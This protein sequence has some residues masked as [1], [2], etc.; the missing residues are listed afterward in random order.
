MANTPPV[1]TI[2]DNS[3]RTLAWNQIGNW[4]TYLDVNGNPAV[5]Y[6]FWDSGAAADSGLIWSDAGTGQLAPNTTLEINAA[7]LSKIWVRGGAVGG[8]ETMWVRAFDGTDWGNWDSFTLTTVPNTA[9]VATVSDHTVRIGE[10]THAS[11][12]ISYSDADGDAATRY[13]FWDSG[14]STSSGYLWSDL[15]TGQQAPNT[16]LDVAASD[17]DKI[18]IRGGSASGS[19]T[20]WV[21]AFD[22]HD[23]GNWDSFTLTT[24]PN[25][26]PVA[27]IADHTVHVDQWSPVSNWLSYS[28]A[29]GDAVTQYQFWDGGAAAT[30]GYIWSDLGTGQQPANS[31][32]TVAASDLSQ[33]WIRGG[34]T[35]GSETMWVRAFDG[36][37]WSNWDSFTLTSQNVAPV[38][39]IADHTAH[40]GQWVRASNWLSSSDAD[41]DA[42]TQYQLWD[43][44]AAATSGYIWSDLGT[45][46]QPAN[47]TLT[48]AASDLSQIW[49]RGGSTTGSE[50]MWVRAFDGHDWGLWDS[51]Q[52]DTVT[53]TAPVAD[54]ADHSL[55]LNE[56]TRVT[57]WLSYF[58]SE[59]DAVT[60]YQFWDGGAGATSGYIWSDLGTGQQPANSTLTVAA[61]DVSQIWLRGGSATGT[62]TM[63][64]RAFDGIDWS[65][66]D[67]FTL[68]TIA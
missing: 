1:A 65:G 21:R 14:T 46:Q 68:T 48:V 38:A 49:L 53:N 43:G 9:P 24:Q 28:D 15:G 47:S 34:S 64:V 45:G 55:H 31:T 13:Q 22:G 52:F 30:S 10:W 37:D 61:S 63:Y 16:V 56:W 32:L 51:F 18:W 29:D 33:I 39:S 6:Q 4:L 8:S 27:S 59:G 58:D 66:W 25:T 67:A 5:K 3:V 40:V 36:H 57:N 11:N 17:L 54:I 41:G 26:A 42:V 62:E 20:F 12:W 50:T 60:Q 23:W 35:T 7:D 2:N 19:E 44:G